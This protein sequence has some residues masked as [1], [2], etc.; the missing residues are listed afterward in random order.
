[1]QE[2]RPH[3]KISQRSL[4]DSSGMGLWNS[5][6]LQLRPTETHD[7]KTKWRERCPVSS[8]QTGRGLSAWPSIFLFLA[9]TFRRAKDRFVYRVDQRWI[10]LLQCQYHCQDW[11]I[12][13]AQASAVPPS[14]SLASRSSSSC[15]LVNGRASW[16]S[17]GL[18]GL[19]LPNRFSFL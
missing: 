11:G 4:Q 9:L 13:L 16:I 12:P 7:A 10:H 18:I 1:M 19:Q 8:F 5:P 15:T 3:R 14:Q 2:L 17:A 6:R